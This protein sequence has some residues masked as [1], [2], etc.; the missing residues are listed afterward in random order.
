MAHTS[1][2]VIPKDL[3]GPF[4]HR[5]GVTVGGNLNWGL[6]V[7]AYQTGRANPSDPDQYTIVVL[8]WRVSF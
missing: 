5:I 8:N 6:R 7:G 3:S 2:A 4:A 1:R